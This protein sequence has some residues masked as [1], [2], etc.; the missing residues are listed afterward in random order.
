MTRV[1]MWIG[2][3]TLMGTGTGTGTGFGTE[4]GTGTGAVTAMG[5]R[6]SRVGGRRWVMETGWMGV[7]T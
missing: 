5:K 6:Y 7:I 4:M 2:T 1:C 3:V